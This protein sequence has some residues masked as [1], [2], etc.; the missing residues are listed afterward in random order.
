MKPRLKTIVFIGAGNVATVLSKGIKDSYNVVQIYS[1]TLASARKL[2]SMLKC[3]YTNDL[4][5]LLDADIYIIAVKDDAVGKVASVLKLKNKLVVHT[6]GSVKME[7]LEKVSSDYGVLYP[8]QTFTKNTK[9]KAGIPICIE[10]STKNVVKELGAIVK[11]L[12]GKAYYLDSDQRSILHLAAVFANNFSNYMFTVAQHIVEE[13]GLPF[14]ILLPLIEETVG[15][16]K[17]NPPEKNQ[18]GPAVRGDKET[19]KKHELLLRNNLQYL[20]LYKLLTKNIQI[21]AAHAK[22][23]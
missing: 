16:L 3:A 2:G 18:T 4:K 20:A 7:V 5:K 13:S 14:E 15:K 21:S 19:I 8:L 10:G 12:N 1:K 17:L 6:S 11:E 9:L 23:L 22:K